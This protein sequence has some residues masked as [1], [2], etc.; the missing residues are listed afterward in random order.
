MPGTLCEGPYVSSPHG[1][2]GGFQHCSG[3]H[4]SAQRLKTGCLAQVSA[5]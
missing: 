5:Q 3:Q 4:N 1:L 2:A